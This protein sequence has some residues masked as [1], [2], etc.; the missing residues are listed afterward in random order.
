M[1]ILMVQLMEYLYPWGGAHKAN[2]ILMEALAK[3]GHECLVI[4]PETFIA[5]CEEY[6][7][8]KRKANEVEILEETENLLCFRIEGVTAYRVAGDYK[9]FSLIKKTID[10]FK[11]DITI[12]SEDKSHLLMESVLETKTR[13]VCLSHSQTVLP[14]GPECF[15]VNEMRAKLYPKCHG[16]IAVSDYLRNYFQKWAGLEAKR[17]YFPSYGEGPF[18]YY[19]N[20]DNPYITVINP[21]AIKGF[22][23]MIGLARRFPQLKF[24][25]VI[26]WST[27][28]IELEELKSI[29]NITIM[30]PVE[31][32]NEIYR[33]TKVF[34]MPSLWGESFGQVV[35]EAMLRGIPVIASNVGG[36]PEAKQ[37]LDYILPVNP[38]KEYTRGKELLISFHRPVVPEQDLE[39]WVQTLD[40]LVHDK[41]HYD[42]LSKI[43]YEE[44]VKFHSTLSFEAFE[45]YFQELIDKYPI[46]LPENK[47]NDA[48]QRKILERINMLPPEKRE[49]FYK[50]LMK[51]GSKSN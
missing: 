36:L 8:K 26:T 3:R 30:Q 32:V 42:Y 25:A 6:F 22:P 18:P 21:S 27:T 41:E 16:I 10:E 34:L 38:I 9:I 19:G 13:T 47:N 14:F 7:E 11:P 43:S 12:V 35:V 1:K 23:I 5:G 4:S 44:A 37:G 51:S 29:N 33:Q 15:E 39:P 40:R 31:D 24:A 45:Q 28:I 46:D 17:I 20:F 49:Q 2:R 48:E 50:L